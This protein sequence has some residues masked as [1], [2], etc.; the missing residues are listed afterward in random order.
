MPTHRPNMPRQRRS[1]PRVPVL[2]P[3]GGRVGNRAFLPC[4]HA[5]VALDGPAPRPAPMTSTSG[6][7]RI[8]PSRLG[9]AGCTTFE[10]RST[11]SRVV[12]PRRRLGHQPSRRSSP[13]RRSATCSW[14]DSW[15]SRPHCSCSRSRPCAQSGA[16]SAQSCRECAGC[17]LSGQPARSGLRVGRDR[18]S[19]H[20]GRRFVR[21]RAPRG[22]DR[23]AGTPVARPDPPESRRA[24]W[25]GALR[26]DARAVDRL[27]A[28]GRSS[29]GGRPSDGRAV[30][31][32]SRA[33]RVRCGPIEPIRGARTNPAAFQRPPG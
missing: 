27:A 16:S 6:G 3:S 23:V 8:S 29:N 15:H 24:P 2:P 31:G 18:G 20:T 30:A 13:G 19:F 7:R 12:H 32:I 21:C 4:P 9:D 17:G 5:A 22:E 10:G 11:S 26:S 33:L 28:A 25:S 1:T 14:S